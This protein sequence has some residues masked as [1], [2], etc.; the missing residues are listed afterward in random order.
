MSPAGREGNEAGRS[1]PLPGRRAAGADPID[2]LQEDEVAMM[3]F[4]DWLFGSEDVTGQA[5]LAAA[6]GP[7]LRIEGLEDRLAP[8][9]VAVEGRPAPVAQALLLAVQAQAFLGN[10]ASTGELAALPIPTGQG[11][12]PASFKD[13]PSMSTAVNDAVFLE[14]DGS[15]WG[16]RAVP[17]DQF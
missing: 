6:G 2:S 1:V 13:G 7:G 15:S 14:A 12:L 9:G 5:S 8:S 3:R 11:R 4:F 16:A 10:G 17:M